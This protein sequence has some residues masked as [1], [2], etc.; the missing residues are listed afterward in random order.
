MHNKSNPYSSGTMPIIK[1]IR[2]RCANSYIFT[3]LL[4]YTFA[5]TFVLSGISKGANLKATSQLISQYCGLLGLDCGIVVSPYILAAVICSFEI[6]IGMA[7]LNRTAFLLTLPVY[8][9]TISLFTILTYINLVAPLGGI[10]SCGCFGELIHLNAKET[11]LKNIL[12]L[13]AAVYLTYKHRHEIT[14][15]YMNIK[16]RMQNF[17][18]TMVLY[19]I[20]AAFPVCVSVYL[21]NK[22]VHAYRVLLYYSSI[23]VYAIFVVYL[24]MRSIIRLSSAVDSDV[25]KDANDTN[26]VGNA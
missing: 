13:I 8:I 1:V 12:L 5:I 9:F 10:E 16:D 20:V 2:H 11:F 6:F 17:G 25:I 26:P 23:V 14:Q 3:Q 7:E 4:K 24:S 15:C 22:D 21:D 18:K 19:A